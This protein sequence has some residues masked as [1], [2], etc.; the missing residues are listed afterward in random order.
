MWAPCRLLPVNRSPQRGSRLARRRGTPSGRRRRAHV[1]LAAPLVFTTDSAPATVCLQSDCLPSARRCISF[2]CIN[3]RSANNRFDDVIELFRSY[4]LSLLCLTETWL[5]CDSPVVGRLRA[6]GYS[7]VDVPRPRVRDDLSVNHGGVAILAAPGCSLSPLLVGPSFSTFEVAAGYVTIGQLRAIVVAVYR[8]G[9]QSVSVKFFDD[10]AALLERLVVLSSMLFVTGDFNVR[11][12]RDDDHHAEQLRSVFDAYGLCVNT[13]GPTHRLGGV[14]DLVAS[15]AAIPLSTDAVDYSDHRLLH[16]PVTYECPT[17][18]A[19]EVSTRPWRLLDMDQLRTSLSTSALCQPSSWPSDVD[20]A[21]SLYGDVMSAILDDLLPVRRVV[22][23]RPLPSDP[24]FDADCRA[25]KRVTRR[26]ERAYL[27][28]SRRAAAAASEPA[29]RAASDAARAAW[30]NQ[31]HAYRRIRHSRCVSFWT[32]KFTAA[33]SPRDRWSVVDRLL[34]RGHRACDAVCADELASYFDDKVRRIRSSTS[35]SSPP[36]YHPAPP[37]ASFL[38]FEPLTTFDVAA[39]ITRLPDKSSAAD[40]LPVSAFKGV[41]DLLT[42]FLTYLFNRSLVD[43]SFPTS[44]KDSF[45]TPIVKKAGL[46]E[47][48]PSSYRPISNLSYISKLLERLVAQQLTRFVARHQLLPSTQSGFRRGHSTETAITFVLSELLNAVDRG[49]TAIL[50]LL[51]LSSAFDTVDH[52]ILLERL[53]VSFGFDGRALSWFRSYLSDRSQHV[54]CG[55][56]RSVASAVVC[57]VPQGSVLGPILFIIYTADLAGVVADC[58]LSSHQYADDNQIFGSCS[59][60]NT[61]TLASDVSHCVELVGDWMGS[62]R[63][64]LNANKTEVMWC[65]SARRLSR[66]PTDPL[67]VAGSSVVPVSVVRDLGVFIDSDLGAATQVRRT[68]SCCFAALRR[69]RYLRRYVSTDCFRSLV[70][71]LVHSRLDYGNFIFVGLPAYQQRRLQSV[72]NAAARMVFNLRRYDHVTDALATLHWLRIPE[73]VNFRLAV[74][75]FRV[76]HGQAPPY[77]S[78][79]VRV[80]DLPARQRLRS[81]SS[82]QLSVPAFRLSTIGRRSFSVAASTVWNSLP[83][84]VQSSPTLPVFRQRL[85]TY[86]FR[87]SFPH[88]AF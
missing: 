8:P 25:A 78:H 67:P 49:D 23:R 1:T 10:L 33:V 5:D 12:D 52:E 46:D 18:Q 30:Q 32:D 13:S 54:R 58:G 2:G 3:I 7:V 55:G 79:L 29:A 61:S 80:A 85:K 50:T 48:D 42:P 73:R 44:F 81:A 83:V 82:Y 86:L 24:W 65:A 43:G 17:I 20:A 27:A 37:G 19:A 62:N 72:L 53:R 74:M 39:A 63:L 26:L 70:V 4:S 21:A 41:A 60:P 87:V 77:L 15:S 9:S 51:D 64:Q 59:P 75:A 38:D 14:L 28:A 16:W 69:L 76:L 66:L 88:V 36:S 56:R 35:S 31:R 11:L 68:V 22:R 34:G 45:L 6:H 47:A 40:P 57:G 84:A 71:S